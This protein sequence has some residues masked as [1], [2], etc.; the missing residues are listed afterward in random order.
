MYQWISKTFRLAPV[1]TPKRALTSQLIASLV[2]LEEAKQF[3]ETPAQLD[4]LT[5]TGGTPVDQIGQAI[6]AR[7]VL[8]ERM[9]LPELTRY[10][11]H[12]QNCYAVAVGSASYARYLEGVPKTV[13]TD[14]A[15]LKAEMKTLSY[16]LRLAYSI[17]HLRDRQL[18]VIRRFCFVFLLLSL[19]FVLGALIVQ[20]HWGVSSSILNLLIIATMGF[21]GA[22]T[23]IARRANQILASNPLDEDPVIQASALQQG[24]ASLLIAALT[25]PVFALVLM[26]VFMS[27]QVSLGAIQPKFS[28]ATCVSGCGNVDLRVFQYTFRFATYAD[29]AKMA[30]WA[31]VAGFA[32]R[33][34][35]DMLDGFVNI[36]KKK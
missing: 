32:E 3:A 4:E 36:G 29:A 10:V 21:G 26:L 20:E 15:L 6:A 34:V 11:Q 8:G 7:L 30:V 19:S 14:P 28:G 5:V 2:D 9:E 16:R 13:F 33:F 17:T 22:L 1:G 35:P 12:L 18:S 31:F 24:S 27:G 25:G 23:S